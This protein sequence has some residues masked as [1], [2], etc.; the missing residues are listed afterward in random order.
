[1]LF[2][3]PVTTPAQ[4]SAQTAPTLTGQAAFTDYSQE[5]PGIRR[6]LTLADL[7]EPHPDES[8]DNG[9]T[10]VPRPDGAWP[11]A[12]AGFKVELYAQGFRQPRLIRTAPNGDLFVADCAAGQDLC[13]A[14]SHS[15]RQGR[16]HE[17]VRHRP[18]PPLWHRVLPFGAESQVD[19]RG[20]RDHRRA[21]RLQVRRPA[22][23]TTPRPKPSFP[24]FPATRSCAAAATGP[25]M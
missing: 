16:G 5:R 18:R 22:S 3:T 2:A 17:Q 1:M 20:Q 23:S 4:T 6:K 8:V 19:L 25:A 21:V 11:I 10:L 15:R 7:P 9:P 24:T 12:P 13:S 14:R